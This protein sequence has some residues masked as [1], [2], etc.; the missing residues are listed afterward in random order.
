MSQTL[1]TICDECGK[2]KGESNNW[3]KL[4]VCYA[5][6]QFATVQ[7][8]QGVLGKSGDKDTQLDLC[9]LECLHATISKL[10]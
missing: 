10:L 4:F 3:H 9:G 8:A 6:K 1:K 5:S 7:L 2:I